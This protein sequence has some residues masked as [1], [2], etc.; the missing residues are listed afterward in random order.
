MLAQFMSLYPGYNL[1]GQF[2]TNPGAGICVG[3]DC[4]GTGCSFI[5]SAELEQLA[6]NADISALEIAF[7]SCFAKGANTDFD[8]NLDKSFWRFFENKLLDSAT[9]SDFGIT[10]NT[11]LTCVTLRDG[12]GSDDFSTTFNSGLT[13]SG[14]SMEAAIDGLISQLRAKVD[15]L[16][17]SC[18]AGAKLSTGSETKWKAELNS[19]LDRQKLTNTLI[20]DELRKTLDANK[21]ELALFNGD[22]DLTPD[23]QNWVQNDNNEFADSHL[24]VSLFLL[25]C[26]LTSLE[27]TENLLG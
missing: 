14:T 5:D 10:E 23:N 16:L 2:K 25:N 22:L 27:P 4:D 12:I 20:N 9:A 3:D 26:F 11:L 21:V 13:F 19:V 6:D 7:Q 18:Q 1:G 15:T 8:L 24:N 17:E